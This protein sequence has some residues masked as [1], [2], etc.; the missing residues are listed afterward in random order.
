MSGAPKVRELDDDDRRLAGAREQ[1]YTPGEHVAYTLVV[2]FVV[3]LCLLGS[4]L[5]GLV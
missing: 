3:G 5:A 2:L 1:R 4:W